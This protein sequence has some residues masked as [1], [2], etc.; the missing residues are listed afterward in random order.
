MVIAPGQ[1]WDRRWIKNMEHAFRFMRPTTMNFSALVEPVA[2][3][4]DAPEQA[5]LRPYYSPSW[6]V[7]L[8]F[9]VHD[10]LGY[11]PEIPDGYVMPGWIK[12]LP[13][14]RSCLVCRGSYLAWGCIHEQGARKPW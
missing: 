3:V 11:P 10:R 8:R 14:E 4:V 5:T 6:R 2:G 12:G 1:E 9:Y 7:V 13:L